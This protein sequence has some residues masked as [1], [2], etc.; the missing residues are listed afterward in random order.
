MKH[1]IRLVLLLAL[2]CTGA[3]AADLVIRVDNVKNA[4]GQV[5]VALFDSAAGFL[6]R[7][8]RVADAPASAGVTTVVIKDLAPGEYGFA[9]YHDANGNGNMDRNL[10]GI[11]LEPFGFSKDAQGRMGPPAFEAVKLAVPAAG[12][13]TAVT[14]R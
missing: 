14:L 4:D 9:V 11:P 8:V 6:K 12:L 10:V 3:Q 13:A 1:P 7:P 5:K 2:A